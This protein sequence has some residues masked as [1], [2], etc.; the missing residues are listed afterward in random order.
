VVDGS[1]SWN[2]CTLLPA[3]LPRGVSAVKV[4]ESRLSTTEVI[5]NAHV[6]VTTIAFAPVVFTDPVV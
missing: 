5:A 4:V 3:P 1:T 6:D 2:I